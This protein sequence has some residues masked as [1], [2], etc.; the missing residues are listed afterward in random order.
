MHSPNNWHAADAV[1][2][3]A[4]VVVLVVVGNNVVSALYPGW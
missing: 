4:E 1:A 2:A 3:L